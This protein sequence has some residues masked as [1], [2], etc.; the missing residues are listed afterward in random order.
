MDLRKFKPQKEIIDFELPIQ[1]VDNL[2]I[3]NDG[4]YKLVARVVPINA[5]LETESTLEH[6]T[7]CIMAALNTFQGRIGIYLQSEKVDISSN[8]D[9]IDGQ[10]KNLNERMVDL[11][12][13]EQTN[14]KM[15]IDLLEKQK[16]HLNELTSVAKTVIYF[17]VVL[18]VRAKEVYTAEHLLKDAFASFSMQLQR[19]GIQMYRVSKNDLRSMLYEKMNPHSAKS[20]PYFPDW[21]LQNLYPQEA[22]LKSGR[23]QIESKK[24][25]FYAIT[26]YPNTVN[27]YRWLHNVFNFE[28]DISIA[29]ILTPKAKGKIQKNLSKAINEYEGKA[30]AQKNAAIKLN[31][32][33]HAK[34]AMDMITDIS[35]ENISIYDVNI[36]IGIASKDETKLESENSLLKSKILG[37]NLQVTELLRK[38]YEPFYTVLPILADNTITRDYVW[39]MTTAD[40][41]SIIPFDSSEYMENR[42]AL[43]AMNH[44]SGGLVITEYRNP[45]YKNGHMTIVAPT[46]AGK[47]YFLWTDVARN[48]PYTDYTIIFDLKG[49]LF[50]PW[51]SRHVFSPISGIVVNPFHIRNTVIDSELVYENGKKDVGLYLNQK[52]M[53]LVEFFKWLIPEMSPLDEAI[54]LEDIKDTYARCDLTFDSKILPSKFCTMS[55]LG[56]VMEEKLQMGGT[57]PQKER[58]E[59]L[60]ACFSPYI[61]GAYAGMFNGQTNWDFD[62]LTVLNISSLP[63]AVSRPIYDILLRDVWQFAK[64][65]GAK[66]PSRKDIYI[67]EAHIFIDP[68]NPQTLDFVSTKLSKMGRGFGIRLVVSTQNLATDLLALPRLGQ[69]ILDNSYFKF[70]MCIGKTDIPIVKQLYNLSDNELKIF[71][72][73]KNNQ[74][75]DSDKGRGIFIIGTQKLVIQTIASKFEM[76]YVPKA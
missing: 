45:V 19:C 70:F 61:T 11:K 12:S 37:L 66:A 9:F 39:N 68:Q 64:K 28:G 76:E 13:L 33:D 29:I 69:P 3:G 14:Y 74:G 65:D 55:T 1:D 38:G 48:F 34:S 8:I 27:K 25:R 21:H 30:L 4:T 67:D 43:V 16:N 62:Y 71:D 53:E 2:I 58:R 72:D 32:Q 36:T 44:T 35:R 18:E 49:D 41:A 59:Y 63:K 15:K 10:M 20:Q 75:K 50:F 17:Y 56:E 54:L 51:G 24:Y 73:A 60:L 5:A 26:G 7:E 47:S 52:I 40:I 42:G 57:G 46:G 6:I 23:I 31:Y 22:T